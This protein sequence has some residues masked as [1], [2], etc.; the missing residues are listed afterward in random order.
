MLLYMPHRNASAVVGSGQGVNGA[1]A[2]RLSDDGILPLLF[3]SHQYSLWEHFCFSGRQ[4]KN[5][6]LL[7]AAELCEYQH[8]VNF[9]GSRNLQLCTY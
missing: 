7:Q 1:V 9:V 5:L 2:I 4:L 8:H 3:E 6:P